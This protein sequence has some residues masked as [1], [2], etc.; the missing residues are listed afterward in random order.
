MLKTELSF[1]GGFMCEV[2]APNREIAIVYNKEILQ[3][4]MTHVI[5]Q[6]TAISIQEALYEKDANKLRI[7]MTKLLKQSVSYYDTAKKALSRPGIGVVRDD[8]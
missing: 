4:R 2:A 7:Q 6:S 8:G 5:P 1:S 3:K